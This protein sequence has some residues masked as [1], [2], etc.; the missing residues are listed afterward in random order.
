MSR[1]ITEKYLWINNYFF[2]NSL[3][4]EFKDDS[5]FLKT[6]EVLHEDS[7]RNKHFWCDIIKFE[8]NYTNSSNELLSRNVTLKISFYNPYIEETLEKYDPFKRELFFHQDVLPKLEELLLSVD[9]NTKLTEKTI[10]V[11]NNRPKPK[12]ILLE[13]LS[14]KKYIKV[15]RKRGLD[16]THLKLTLEKLAKLHATS[17]VLSTEKDETFPHHQEPNISES[18]KI[19]YSLFSN[20]MQALIEEMINSKDE[21]E[22]R[23]GRK[24]ENF[25]KNMFDK[26]T[27]A[28]LLPPDDFYVLCHGDLWMNNLL[29]EYDEETGQPNDVS[30]SDFGLSYFGSPGIDLSYLIFTSSS[31]DIKDYEIDILL[32]FYQ[33]NL[34]ANLIKLNYSQPIPSLIQV[35]NFF[36][37]CGVIGFVY[38]CLLLPIRF[39]APALLKDMSAFVEETE[40]SLM[41]RKELFKNFMLK[42]RL[43]FL[44]YYFDRKGVLE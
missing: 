17:A 19:F 12:Y 7:N 13:E 28:F 9:D 36:L 31:N 35:H 2:E 10:C 14:T 34:H 5:I 3:R 1:N 37:K 4:Q 41:I 24:L 18:S 27:E 43:R 40:D 30:F 33:Q 32:Q 38:S 39:A 22:K 42:D 6:F 29:F 25:E 44:L 26:S 21:D 8:I 11:A 20:C 23:L 16:M 15:D